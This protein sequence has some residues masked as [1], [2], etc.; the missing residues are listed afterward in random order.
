MTEFSEYQSHFQNIIIS[1]T[2][3]KIFFRRPYY[4]SSNSWKWISYANT[5]LEKTIF[6]I[7]DD[8]NLVIATLIV[9][10]FAIG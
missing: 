7:L 6:I 10:P 4:P 2:A 5:F 8:D 1:S 9:K 3:I